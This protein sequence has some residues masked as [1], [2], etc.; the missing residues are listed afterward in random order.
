MPF[1]AAS[2]IRS[3]SL[4]TWFTTCPECLSSM[5]TFN[6]LLYNRSW[7]A[8]WSLIAVWAPMIQDMLRQPDRTSWVPIRHKARS[9]P[10]L[11]LDSLSS[12][13]DRISRSSTAGPRNWNVMPMQ[14]RTPETMA[15]V[16]QNLAAAIQNCAFSPCSSCS[17]FQSLSSLLTLSSAE[18]LGAICQRSSWWM[19]WR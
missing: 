8:P 10:V 3:M 5:R 1:M 7:I 6:I 16:L 13:N 19:P 18:S 14:M 2:K 15:R 11:V 9:T 4:V 17:S 12:R